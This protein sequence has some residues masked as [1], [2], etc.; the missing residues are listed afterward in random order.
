MK[1][2]IKKIGN[3]WYAHTPFV[4]GVVDIETGVI[5]VGDT[6]VEA[7]NDWKKQVDSWDTTERD[8]AIIWAMIIA[9][10]LVAAVFVWIFV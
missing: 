10:A 9:P 5:G 7:Y 6:P 3:G 4:S 8:N 2:K 1:A